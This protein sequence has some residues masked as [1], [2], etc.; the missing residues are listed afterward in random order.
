MRGFTTLFLL[1]GV[2]ACQRSRDDQPQATTTSSVG[3]GVARA[4]TQQVTPPFDVKAPPADATKTASG[5][6][7]KKLV[8]NATGSPIKRN[9][10]VLINY[11]GWRQSTGDTFFTNRSSGQPLPLNLTQAAP[12]F[13]EAMQLL[14]KGEKAVLWV[15]AAIGYKAPPAQ[16]TPEALVYEVEVVDITPA[17]AIPD[18]VAK[19]P[20]NAVALPSGT[21][22]VVARPGTSKDKVRQFDTV[23]FNYTAWDSDGRMIDTTE[24]RNRTVTAPP[25]KQSAAMGEMLTSLAAGERGRF[26]VDSEKMTNGGKPLPGVQKGQLCY[27][28]EIVSAVKAPH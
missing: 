12:G 25:Y 27:E 11:T 19:P 4:R 18:N 6:V 22:L 7:Y 17:P 5:L 16:G 23:T 1:L 21:K 26:W 15:P 13:V 2:V 8:D 3:S 10:T 28:V 24:Q 9:D 14:H 20:D